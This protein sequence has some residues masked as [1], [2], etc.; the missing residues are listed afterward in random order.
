MP[1]LVQGLGL[2]GADLLHDGGALLLEPGGALLILD[3]DALLLVNSSLNSPWHIHTTL[4][5]NAVTLVLKH[6]LTLLLHIGGGLTLPLE[7]GPAL[8]LGLRVLNRPLGDLT[9][10]LVGVGIHSVH[11]VLEAEEARLAVIHE[12]DDLCAVLL[13]SLHP[14]LLT[15]KTGGIE[16]LPS[17]ASFKKLFEI[18]SLRVLGHFF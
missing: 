17:D 12:S 1:H 9:L 6:L 16:L 15:V 2:G 13:L 5:R 3:G 18:H 10:P 4:L 8:A 11:L 7:L 14:P